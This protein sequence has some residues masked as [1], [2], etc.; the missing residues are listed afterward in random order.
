MGFFAGYQSA[1]R[2][3]SE[4]WIFR[5]TDL[6]FETEKTIPRCV[7]DYSNKEDGALLISGVKTRV[8]SVEA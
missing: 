5:L 7:I 6:L 8:A 2:S 4:V 3:F 1:I